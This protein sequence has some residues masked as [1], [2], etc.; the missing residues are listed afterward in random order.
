[1]SPSLPTLQELPSVSVALTWLLSDR[2]KITDRNVLVVARLCGLI[3]SEARGGWKVDGAMATRLAKSALKRL[4]SKP[5]QLGDILHGLG[6]MAARAHDAQF[7]PLVVDCLRRRRGRLRLEES[8]D[9]AIKRDGKIR[10]P[11]QFGDLA[12]AQWLSRANLRWDTFHAA[13]VRIGHPHDL[14]GGGR[15]GLRFAARVIL[16]V[17]SRAIDKWIGAHP[18][19]PSVAAIGG[20]A[21]SMV[22][23]FDGSAAIAPLLKSRNAAIRCLAAVSIVCPVNV[24]PLLLSFHECHAALVAGG[25]EAADATWMTGIRIKHAIHERY[26]LE[27]QREQETARLR[28]LE[29]S[30]DGATGGRRNAEAELQMLRT[31]LSHREERYSKLLPELEEM[32]NSMATDWPDEGL[33]DRQMA[34]LENIFVDTAEFRHRLAE[35]L[36]HQG[37]REWLLKRNVSRL[38]DFIGLAG[39]PA[40]IPTAHFHANEQRFEAIEQWTARSLILLYENDTRGIGKRTSDLVSVVAMAAERLV[41]Q[42]FIA[43]RKPEAWQSVMA[44]AA[45]ADRFALTVV[46]RVPEGQRAAVARLNELAIDH[47]FTILCAKYPPADALQ[48]FHQLSAQAVKQMGFLSNPDDLR[49]K[50]GLAEDLPDFSRALAIWSSANLVEKHKALASMLFRRNGLLPLS[51]NGSD[52]Q[53]SRLLTLLDLAIA[54]CAIAGR[55]DLFPY[56]IG[57]WDAAY[58]DWLPITGQWARTAEQLA[59]AVSADGSERAALMANSSFATSYCRQLVD[60]S[61]AGNHV[62]DVAH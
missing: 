7:L 57:L 1:M 9:A 16:T 61:G 14:F 3:T 32:L 11:V 24:Q 36:S 55:R 23:P 19:S 62:A 21:L 29:Q 45:C 35:K 42:P 10:R 46:A 6:E 52:L 15:F 40:D 4:P 31:R 30:P 54:S 60:A 37:N 39:K 8:L 28:Y 25:F 33:S 49:E 43:S 27:H 2:P 56:V 58:R 50:W 47:T 48:L 41:E 53:M 12:F 18:D 5:G 17:D 20:A 59:A 13:L 34:A 44:R 51:R 38:R 22:F 26:G